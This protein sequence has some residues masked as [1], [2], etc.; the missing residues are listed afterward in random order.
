VGEK[1]VWKTIPLWGNVE[2]EVSRQQSA[3]SER[4]GSETEEPDE[5]PPF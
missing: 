2:V 4:V 1:Q 3:K 5:N